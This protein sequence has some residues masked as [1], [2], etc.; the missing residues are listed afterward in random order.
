MRRDFAAADYTTVIAM[1]NEYGTEKWHRN[2][3]LVRLAALKVANGSE[4]KL[5]TCIDSAKQD[6][7]ARSC[8]VCK[9]IIGPRDEHVCTVL[10]QRN[11]ISSERQ[12]KFPLFMWAHDACVVKIIPNAECAS[13]VASWQGMSDE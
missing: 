1:L 8:F 2:P 7:D 5:R 3:M 12:I 6:P 4:Q 9:G 10:I 11:V 13:W